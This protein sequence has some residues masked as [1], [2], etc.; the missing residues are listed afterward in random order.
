M[1]YRTILRNSTLPP[2]PLLLSSDT[3]MLAWMSEST[4]VVCGLCRYTEQQ[5]QQMAYWG[6]LTDPNPN[7]TTPPSKQRPQRQADRL[8]VG[9]ALHA[10]VVVRHVCFMR[11]DDQLKQVFP[12]LKLFPAP[13]G[14]GGAGE[15]TTEQWLLVFVWPDSKAND[16]GH[17]D[18]TAALQHR[19]FTKCLH[20]AMGNS[21][22]PPSLLLPGYM[23]DAFALSMPAYHALVQ[24]EYEQQFDIQDF[25]GNGEGTKRA[26]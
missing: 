16:T 21:A 11:A 22:F 20:F 5:Y 2:A 26:W 25:Q 17:M 15:G 14:T 6:L 9:A 3:W 8:P 13:T 4:A 7:R 12:G 1:S 10:G 24:W 18:V 19:D 23:T